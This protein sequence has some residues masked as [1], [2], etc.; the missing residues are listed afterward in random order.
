MLVVDEAVVVVVV[1]VGA[2]G[3]IVAVLKTT[4]IKSSLKQSLLIVGQALGRG[5]HRTWQIDWQSNN[6][7]LI[8]LDARA[9]GCSIQDARRA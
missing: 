6:S 7:M 4:S 9:L 2:Y 1:D 3:N 5:I 8:G